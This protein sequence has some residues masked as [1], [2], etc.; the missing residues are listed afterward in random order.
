MSA[1]LAEHVPEFLRSSWGLSIGVVMA[2]E[3]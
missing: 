2:V 1:R 3:M